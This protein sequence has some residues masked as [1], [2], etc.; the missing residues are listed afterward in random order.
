MHKRGA[1][2]FTGQK[3]RYVPI[4]ETIKGFKAIINGDM[5]EYPEEAFFMVGN[6]EEVK[7]KAEKLEAESRK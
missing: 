3:G 5:D 6:I 1:E 4:S 2:N 7:Q